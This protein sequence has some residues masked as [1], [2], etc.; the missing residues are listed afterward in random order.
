LCL[1]VGA[2]GAAM[3]AS[4][5]PGWYSSLTPPAAALPRWLFAP[6]WTVLHIM[7]GTAAWLV[8]R[9]AGHAAAL[10]LWGWQ[11]L[12]NALWTPVF[13]GLHRPAPAAAVILTLFVLILLTA[14]AF[15]RIDRTAAALM[16]PYAAWVAYA[17]YLN[18]GFWWLNHA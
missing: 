14:R 6:V 11:L 7:I 17:S 3:T 18:L 12:L 1:L 4:S 9:R 2:A 8:W 15:A 5:V 13:F 10:R 16:L